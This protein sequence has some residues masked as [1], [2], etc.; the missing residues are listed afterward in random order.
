MLLT[1]VPRGDE[2]VVRDITPCVARQR[3]ME[4][5]A[6][7]GATIQSLWKAPFGGCG[8]YRTCGSVIALRNEDAACIDV[9]Y[10]MTRRLKILHDR[11]QIPTA[12]CPKRSDS[13]ISKSISKGRAFRFI[14]SSPKPSNFEPTSWW[15]AM[16]TR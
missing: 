13:C 7:P 11:V 4:L 14:S 12:A 16:T 3:L 9:E 8:C 15:A 10:I 6:I 5:G 2:V 1:E